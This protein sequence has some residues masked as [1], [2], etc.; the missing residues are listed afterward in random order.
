M[1]EFE[2][3]D[4]EAACGTFGSLSAFMSVPIILS[5]YEAE[6]DSFVEKLSNLE[7][8]VYFIAGLF[9]YIVAILPWF[10][11]WAFIL[12]KPL[13]KLILWRR[14]SLKERLKRTQEEAA[15]R[16]AAQVRKLEGE[17]RAAAEAASRLEAQTKAKEERAVTEKK[18]WRAIL[19]KQ[20]A[21]T[22]H[23]LRAKPDAVRASSEQIQVKLFEAR[24]G[25]GS[26]R[27]AIVVEIEWSA[28]TGKAIQLILLRDT[29]N[30]RV[31]SD[32]FPAETFG[33]VLARRRTQGAFR[34]VDA[35]ANPGEVYNY[36]ILFETSAAWKEYE[37]GEYTS[38][39]G[40]KEKLLSDKMSEQT[41]GHTINGFDAI[42][43]NIST[44]AETEIDFW[45]RQAEVGEA[46]ARAGKFMKKPKP[47]LNPRDFV[48]R[49]VGDVTEL[50]AAMSILK[51]EIDKAGLDEDMAEAIEADFLN[52]FENK[53]MDNI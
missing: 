52:N 9:I 8:V 49:A 36:Y 28:P 40:T 39:D 3:D 30:V 51:S 13:W 50:E 6:F 15:A 14:A 33:T 46:K 35:K 24:P 5:V 27:N 31:L 26:E 34:Y 18:A 17:R 2:E 20:A 29:G 21:R 43:A 32:R 48:Q 41:C 42:H 16:E 25:R 11:F 45:N 38:P 19:D 23:N 47:P 7:L 10:W 12:P 53:K 4:V 22:D 44:L 37:L 1:S